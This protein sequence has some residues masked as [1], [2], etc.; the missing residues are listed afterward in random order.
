MTAATLLSIQVGASAE[1]KSTGT[2]AWWDRT[3]V[4]GFNKFSVTSPVWLAYG[5]LRGDEQADRVH[6]GGV[7]KAVCV[8]PVEH[9][10][11]WRTVP[12]L[13]QL[14]PG[15]FGENFTTRG[16]T[17]ADVS[18]GDIFEVG[19]ARVQISQ[20][21]QPCWKLARRRRLKHLTAWV[22][23][24]GRTGYYLRVLRHGWIAPGQELKLRERPFPQFTVAHANRIMHHAKED[25]DAARTLT[26]CPALSASW[27]DNLWARVVDGR[28]TS[29]SARVG[30]P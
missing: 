16:L 10:S 18:I 12:E 6:H 26:G 3:W 11:H 29:A 24:T 2:D 23:Q 5:G 14:N 15:A 9:Y 19:E 8:Y 7:E 22:E 13:A 1:I 4:S 17:E 28:S 27:K 21:R 20:P 25:L 30:Q